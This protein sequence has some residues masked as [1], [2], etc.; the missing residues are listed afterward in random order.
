MFARSQQALS[1]ASIQ[2]SAQSIEDLSKLKYLGYKKNKSSFLWLPYVYC[3]C[4][5]YFHKRL[6][7]VLNKRTGGQLHIWYGNRIEIKLLTMTF[8]CSS[9]CYIFNAFIHSQYSLQ[10]T[11]SFS[12]MAFQERKYVNKLIIYVILNNI[13]TKYPKD[14]TSLS[15]SNHV[16][17]HTVIIYR[18]ETKLIIF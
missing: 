11:V 1:V 14:S 4:I 17:P 15:V 18:H 9:N 5:K 7:Q 16:N 2:N 8:A 10:P 12:G 6:G 13:Q 3:T